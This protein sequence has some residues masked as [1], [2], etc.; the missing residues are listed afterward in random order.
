[1]S[2]P[3]GQLSPHR[4][5]IN[6]LRTLGLAGF[7]TIL[8]SFPLIFSASGEQ[9]TTQQYAATTPTLSPT[10]T[11]DQDVLQANATQPF[12]IYS[13][14]LVAQTPVENGTQGWTRFDYTG[15]N[16]DYANTTPVFTPPFSIRF[17]STAALDWFG[18]YGT[19]NLNLAPYQSLSFYIQPKES[20]LNYQVALI[21]SP[22]GNQINISGNWVNLP[23]I[24]Q[25][26]R[27]TV[28]N[29]PLSSF[30]AGS[31]PVH[32][33]AFK[34]I[35]GGRALPFLATYIDEVAFTAQ[36]Y[37]PAAQPTAGSPINTGANTP[38]PVAA[39]NERIYSPKIDPLVFIVPAI[40]IFAAMFF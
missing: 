4:H 7:L 32:G 2:N 5:K 33:I 23:V 25:P 11:P 3:L 6:K 19:V 35:S 24:A 28:Y 40:I 9:Q 30:N 16:V 22:D 26:G 29:I 36:P 37:P 15:G 13:N 12:H 10:L 8:I 39:P 34:E 20:G 31:S 38:T 14:N 1:M 17:E 27:W 18:L 21:N